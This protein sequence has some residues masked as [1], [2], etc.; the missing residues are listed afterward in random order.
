MRVGIFA[1]TLLVMVAVSG[2]RSADGRGGVRRPVSPPPAGV[3]P[4]SS[5]LAEPNETAILEPTGPITLNDALT[6]ALVHNPGLKIYPY[7]LRAVEARMVQAG[8]WP[9][10]ELQV[11]VEEFGGRGE[12]SSF[13]AAETTVQI[14]Q[15]IELGGKRAR[16]TRVA[17]AGKELAQ[18]DYESAR[19]DLVRGVSQAF[20]AVLAAQERLGL[21]ERLL[22]LSR[23]AQSAVVQR[24]QAG[25][26]SPVDAMR[27]GVVMSESRIERQKAEKTL[28]AARRNLAALWGS[29]AP[30]FAAA[31]GQWYEIAPLAS[32]DLS[33]DAVAGNPDV[34]RWEAEQRSRRAALDLEKAKAV[35]DVTAAGGVRRYEL[36][37][38]SAFVL[39][40]AVPL[41]LFDRNQGGIREAVANLGAARR[42]YEAVRV[43]TLAALSEA[44][45]ALAA[46]HDEMAALKSE[47]L[48]GAQQ[49]FEAVQ[50]GYLQG[51]FDYL[52]VLDTQ[53]TL[54]ETQARYINSI[55]AYHKARADA[56]RLTGRSLDAESNDGRPSNPVQEPSSQVK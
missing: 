39:G 32:I 33:P 47:V 17:A 43:K 3:A 23:Q 21:A 50:Q 27:A 28:T 26:D 56:E 40:L 1:F 34:A 2:C 13:D 9:N 6:L 24:V 45:T 52:Y 10:P 42:Q 5:R 55:E 15:P 46:A 36:T 30:A 18:W 53:R 16:R 14:G 8:L 54:F 25:R 4:A 38:D 20:T 51:K 37:D 22:D 19:L 41:P 29:S 48:P 7:S 35:P 31:S 44:A 11:E 12:R 49:A